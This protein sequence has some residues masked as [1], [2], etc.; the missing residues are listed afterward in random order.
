MEKKISRTVYT[1]RLKAV[2]ASKDELVAAALAGKPLQ[3]TEE[4]FLLMDTVAFTEDDV[5]QKKLP[6]IA[7][8]KL[9]IP[10]DD[11]LHVSLVSFDSFVVSQTL[12]EFL[13]HGTIEKPRK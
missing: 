10:V 11:I 3:A 13:A 9:A 1:M 2:I 12:D 7:A 6:K 8:E 4:E 5:N